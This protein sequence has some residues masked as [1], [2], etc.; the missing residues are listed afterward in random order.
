MRMPGLTYNSNGVKDLINAMQG[1]Q[2]APEDALM[3][4]HGPLLAHD[5]TGTLLTQPK[6]WSPA[7]SMSLLSSSLIGQSSGGDAALMSLPAL[8]TKP[9]GP[10]LDLTLL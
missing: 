1:Y 7:E 10:Y 5:P 4:A 6:E 8:M 9:S 3:H 2:Y